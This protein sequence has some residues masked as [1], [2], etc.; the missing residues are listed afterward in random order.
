MT[1]ERGSLEHTEVSVGGLGFHVVVA[2]PSDARP[3]MLLHG[4]PEF[5]YGWRPLI[6]PLAEAGFR[7]IV[8][9]QRGYGRSAKPGAVADYALDLLASDAVGIAGALGHRDF[10]LI[11]HDWGGIV[12]WWVAL[13]YRKRVR[14]LVVVNAPH[15]VAARR[16]AR[17]R[18]RQLAKSWYIFFFQIPKLPEFFLRVGDFALLRAALRFSAPRGLFGEEDYA[19]YRE[20]WSEPGAL[21]A[22]LDWYRAFPKFRA[23]ETD[24]TVRQPTLIIW[25]DRD[26]FLEFG[27]AAASAR[28]CDDAR[29][30]RIEGASHWVHHEGPERVAEEIIAFLADGGG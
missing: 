9:D 15:P 10:D 21:T 1:A 22:M 30:V 14:R 27:L 5:W 16:Y 26:A 13:K 18:W 12:A 19:A 6:E 23:R 17:W 11:G 3:V 28:F 20:A 8:P 29:I 4:F 2:G 25:G 7:V 24:L